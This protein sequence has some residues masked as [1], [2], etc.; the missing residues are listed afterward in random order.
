[1]GA[2]RE[3]KYKVVKEYD[4]YYLARS[5]KGWKEC[6]LKEEFRREWLHNEI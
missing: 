4:K 6:F 3:L 5:E 2:N 1:M